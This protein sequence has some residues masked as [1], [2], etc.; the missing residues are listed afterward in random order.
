MATWFI[1]GRGPPP[2]TSVRQDAGSGKGAAGGTSSGAAGSAGSGAAVAAGSAGSG[3]ADAA[4]AGEADAAGAG[5]G[6][7]GRREEAEAPAGAGRDERAEGTADAGRGERAEEATGAGASD[8][9]GAGRGERAAAAVVVAVAAASTAT[10]RSRGYAAVT[11][12]P[13]QRTSLRSILGSTRPAIAQRMAAVARC[14]A[15]IRFARR[16]RAA[17]GTGPAEHVIGPL[18][19][20]PRAYLT[21]FITTPR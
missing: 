17:R 5:A 21:S 1:A 9:A 2:T 11:S 10:R 12:R 6:R 19:R 14:G 18:Q 15:A 7:G 8:A 20:S 13:R 16:R 3:A 4:G